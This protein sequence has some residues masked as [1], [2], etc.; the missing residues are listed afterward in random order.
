MDAQARRGAQK[1]ANV[2]VSKNV[3]GTW[4]E[5]LPTMGGAR[6]ILRAPLFCALFCAPLRYKRKRRLRHKMGFHGLP[7]EPYD[8]DSGKHESPMP[9][10]L[11]QR[12]GRKIRARPG[13][14]AGR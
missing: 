3:S 8:P 5:I 11:C 6:K 2:L 1:S 13:A 12:F 4:L 9:P 7:V 10:A 14:A